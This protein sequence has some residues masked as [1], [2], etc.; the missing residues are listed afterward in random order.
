MLQ[1][2]LDSGSILSSELTDA[3][4][5]CSDA[6]HDYVENLRVGIGLPDVLSEAAQVLDF[7][8]L[9]EAAAEL[10]VEESSAAQPD[11]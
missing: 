8:S 5:K 10:A 11:G 6:L 2:L 3:V 7:A 4:L 1:K 9:P